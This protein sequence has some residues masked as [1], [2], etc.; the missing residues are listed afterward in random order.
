[1]PCLSYYTDG[2]MVQVVYIS[3]DTCNNEGEETADI[4]ES[5]AW[6]TTANIRLLCVRRT[7]MSNI[8][9]VK[10]RVNS[11]IKLMNI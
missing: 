3:A 6:H 8:Y 2:Y 5:R 10:L 9:K 4:N 11:I 1:M 7:G